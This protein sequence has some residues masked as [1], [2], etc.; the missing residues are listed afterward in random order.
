MLYHVM[1]RGDN[2]R[3]IFI[4]DDDYERFLA[5]LTKTTERFDV[6]CYAYCLL[7]SHVHLLLQPGEVPLSRMMQQLNSAYCQSFNRRHDRVGHVL[8]GRYKSPLVDSDVYFLR[9]LRYIVRNPVAAG[10]VDDP[11]EWHWSSFRAT[12][13]LVDAPPFLDVGRVWTALDATDAA[14]A[15][16]RLAT[17]VSTAADDDLP[18]KLFLIGPEAFA[19]QFAPRLRPYRD[20]EDFIHAERFAARPPLAALMSRTDARQRLG[21]A[22]RVAF[23]EHAYTLREIGTYVGRPVATVWVWIQLAERE[24]S[25]EARLVGRGSGADEKIEI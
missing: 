6:H 4:D 3:Q 5:L 20:T 24:S 17:F 21:E 1:S 25:K 9:L 10:C 11:A 19:T 18:D 2:K 13:G 8:Q 22:A 16:A 14:T 23:C 7:W 15:R 12:V